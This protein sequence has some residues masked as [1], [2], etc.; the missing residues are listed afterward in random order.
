[1]AARRLASFFLLLLA[2]VA[3]AAAK[4]VAWAHESAGLDPD[5]RVV[6]GALDNGLRYALL[7]RDA[8]PGAISMRFMVEVGSL[9]ER[10][11]ERGLSHFIEH[12]AF[13]GTRHFKPGELIAFFQRLGMSYGVDVNAFTYHDKTVYHLELP[14]NEPELIETSLLLYRD[15]ADGMLFDPERVDNEREVI[16]RE[17]AARETPSARIARESFRFSF[18]GS[19]LADRP[20]IGLESVIREVTPGELKRF[21][22]KWY[23]PELMTLVV[24]GDFDPESLEASIEGA[25][26]SLE[27]GRGW[28]PRRRVGKVRRDKSYRVGSL[29]VEGV[30]R[31]TLEVSRAWRERV[32]GDSWELR[33]TDARRSFATS[34]FNERCRLLIDGMSENFANYDRIYGIPYCQLT[35]SS[36]GDF[37]WDAFVWMDQLLRQALL[38]GFT[39]EELAYAKRSWLSAS[40]AATARARSAEPRQ[41]VDELVDSIAR[42]RVYVS[43]EES[44]ERMAALVESLTLQEV[45]ETFAE[46][47]DLERLSYFLAGD[48]SEPL[49]RRALKQRLELDRRYVVMPF[50]PQ[51]PGSFAYSDLGEP[52]K[53]VESGELAGVGARTFRFANNARLTFLRTENEKDTVRALV[54]VGGGMLA[55]T[56][57]NPGTHALAMATLFRSGFGE[58]NID[59]IYQELRS[60]V[61]SF[62][63]GVEDH[64]A[65]TYRALA[66]VEGLDAILKIVAEYLLDPRV[67]TEA[68]GL[69]QSK[70]AQS[71]EL[72]PDGLNE[73]YRELYR[74][75]YP[76]QPRFHPPSLPDI[77]SV[78]PERIRDWLEDPFRMG[79]LEVAIVGDVEEAEVLEAFSETL[80]ALPEREERKDA[81]EAARRLRVAPLSGKRVIEYESGKGDSAASVVVWTIQDALDTRESAALYILTSVLESRI[82]DRVRA[83]MGASYAPSA[84]YVTFPAYDTLRHIRADVDCSRSD[85]PVLLDVVLEIASGLGSEGVSEDELQAAVAPMEEGLRQAWRDNGYLLENVLYGAQEYPSMVENA[86]SYREGLLATITVEE[87][88]EAARRYLRSED[89]LAVAIVPAEDPKL[90]EKPE[91]SKEL[92]AGAVEER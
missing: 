42:D 74:M 46:I 39:E 58:H 56:D 32:R 48:L 59:E 19:R 36:G 43:A 67:E 84:R 12:M 26:S 70:L 68:F 69:A 6:W 55:F 85:A 38:Y 90:A 87:L 37:W 92:R 50:A 61:S 89:A 80:G 28:T 15:Y 78:D 5:P 22:E 45:N 52:G 83:G 17:K 33:E 13:E 51:V 1:M 63:F 72:E 57:S 77:R 20:P 11:R 4:P 7:P 14:Q 27:P 60:N 81:F 44:G 79:Y 30:E 18:G 8:K 88:Q 35:L 2:P 23:R 54:R 73:G 21:Y 65:F 24:V 75:M 82:R 10:E 53:V 91:W 86:L 76:E 3:L 66:P 25:F 29:Q 31:H 47:W 40:R 41:L 9:D 34:L 16:L 62:V 71:R 64:D 49:E